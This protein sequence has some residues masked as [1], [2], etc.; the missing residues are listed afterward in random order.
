MKSKKRMNRSSLLIL[1][2]VG[3]CSCKN[4]GDSRPSLTVAVAANAQYAAEA[5]KEAFEKETAIEVTLIIASSGKL[6]AQIQQAAPYDLFLSADMDYPQYLFDEKRATTPPQVYAVGELVLW[7]NDK[8][9]SLEDP[10]AV[11]QEP[12]IQ[13]I[14]IAQVRTAPYGQAA[15]AW[16]TQKGVMSRVESKLV[17]GENIAQVNSYVLSGAAQLGFTA[18]S[19]VV[20]PQLA[21]QG[22]FVLL[23]RDSYPAIE[24]GMVITRHGHKNHPEASQSFWNFMQS[25]R[26][27]TILQQYGYRIPSSSLEN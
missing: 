26:A 16:L 14:A 6:T 2:L 17:F 10:V 11:L 27:Q 3:L 24:Q 9:L 19:V 23:T 4:S 20:S 15:Q 12:D 25:T 22:S 1:V 18:R 8:S 7:T 5:L 13:R 21:G